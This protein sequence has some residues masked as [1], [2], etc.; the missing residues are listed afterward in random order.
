MTTQLKMVLP[1]SSEKLRISDELAKCFDSGDGGAGMTAFLVSPFSSA[2]WQVEVGRDGDGAFL[3]RRWPEFVE[4]HGISVGWFLVFRHVGR[5][6]LTIKAF[7]GTFFIKE[8][9]QTLTVP[10]LPAAHIETG[11]A[12]RPQFLMPLF[13]HWMD[14]MPI[15]AEFL[16]RRY[17]PDE[18]LN[19][20][21]ATFMNPSSD[22]WHIDLE[23]D[24]S[25]VFFAGDWSKFLK[26]HGIA[27]GQ[28]LLIR[29]QGNMI[30][31]FKV[32]E[33][34]G[35]R[36]KLVKQGSRFQL[37]ENSEE[38][39]S[40]RDTEQNEEANPSQKNSHS[41]EEA[42]SQ[43]EAHISSTRR[44]RNKEQKML[45]TSTNSP[46]RRRADEI[47]LRISMTKTLTNYA[48]ERYICLPR[49]FTNEI[50]FQESCKITLK[51]SE[52]QRSWEVNYLVE[53]KGACNLS[54]GWKMFCQDL[55]LK[56]GD[57]CTFNVIK[58]SLWH[59]DIERC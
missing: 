1:G 58:R 45:K 53:K 12:R 50:G 17:I 25:N 36:R 34:T 11:R 18:E 29:Y 13:P 15:P 59:V 56:E 39:Y 37:T 44:K 4:A 47:Q 3:G 31:T 6:M 32:F 41:S 57:K 30:F 14:K 54:A 48:L 42:Q 20:R 19:R 28:A 33:L 38:T 2:I 51:S 49:W 26:F 43:K 21:K 5:G 27:L 40:S 22:L 35:C 55:G 46:D 24:G 23:K 10:G 52:C 8:F 16:K 7:D 9:G